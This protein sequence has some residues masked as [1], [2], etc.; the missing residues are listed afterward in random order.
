MNNIFWNQL[1]SLSDN[2]KASTN[3]KAD[4]IQSLISQLE[5]ICI[6]HEGEFEPADEFEEYVTLT[7]CRS[8]AQN[9]KN[10]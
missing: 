4:N 3:A 9:L 10:Q 6:S 7:L 2:L 5:S 1:L 8:I